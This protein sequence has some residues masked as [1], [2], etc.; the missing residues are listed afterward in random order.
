MKYISD[1]ISRFFE[2]SFKRNAR[3][4]FDK[5]MLKYRDSDNT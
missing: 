5:S 3:K 4:Q 2:W 1:I